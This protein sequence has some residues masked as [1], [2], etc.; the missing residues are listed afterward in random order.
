MYARSFVLMLLGILGGCSIQSAM[1]RHGALSYDDIIEDTTDKFLL[2]N[3]LR[4]KDKA[5]LHFDDIPLIHESIQ[6]TA[7]V[8]ATWPFGPR[9]P[10]ANARNTVT[11]GLS[12]QVTPTFDVAHLDTK[13]FVTGLASPIDPKFVKYWLDRGLDRRIVML[14]FFSSAT[15]TETRAGKMA[16]TIRLMNSPRAAIST[17][18]Q[19]AAMV[20]GGSISEELRCDATS[21]FQ[22]YLKFINSLGQ[23]SARYYKERHLF[24]T[25]S[26]SDPKTNLKDLLGLDPDKYQ[27][28]PKHDDKKQDDNLTFDVFAISPSA[29]TTLCPMDAAAG[30]GS[31]FRLQV[32]TVADNSAATE[33]TPLTVPAVQKAQQPSPYCRLFN[34]VVA[35]NGLRD[36]DNRDATITVRLEMRS[37][38]EMIQFLGDLLEYQ[39]RLA[40]ILAKAPQFKL[41]EPLTFGYCPDQPSA[42][43]GDVF[44]NLLSNTCNSRFAVEYRGRIYAVPNY[45]PAVDEA[46]EASGSFVSGPRGAD[47]T[48]E[49]L[50]VVHQMVDLQKSAQ[51]IRETP[52]VQ[53]LP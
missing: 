12:L 38:G 18:E 23:L 20:Q 48:L 50:A 24:T 29:V 41:N 21:D 4:A 40:G 7:S 13:D 19:Q 17:L 3:I 36:A 49:V 51:D 53:V 28:T 5:P 2:L 45:S 16:T 37:V 14:L 27:V 34:G 8:Q 44:F 32:E 6:A 15:I 30:N 10:S 42:G 11:P 35:G 1:I 26:L 9:T 39:E 52:Y 47:H 33:G 43:C 46:C 31:C 22:H 25:V